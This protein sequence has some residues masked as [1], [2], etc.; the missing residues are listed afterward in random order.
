MRRV[1]KVFFISLASLILLMLAAVSIM[2]WLV[3]T[4]ER[5]T[6]IIRNQSAKHIPYQTEV[7]EVELTFFSTFPQFGIKIKNFAVISPATGATSDT[8]LRADELVG[9]IDTR[10]Y[11]ENREIIIN[12]FILSNSYLNIFTD[13]L[14]KSN[15]GLFMTGTE[16]DPEG[17]PD[18]DFGFIELEK[19]EFRKL[20]LSYADLPAKLITAITG[21]NA[22]I[23]ATIRGDIM[24]GLMNISNAVISFEYDGDKY[25]EDARVQLNIPAE[26]I[27]SRQL[28]ELEEAYAKIN[29]VGIT[30]NGSVEYDTF[31]ESFITD[32]RY[33]SDPSKIE[34]VIALIPPA[35]FPNF[36]EY[37]ASGVITSEGIIKGVLN[38]SLMPLMDIGIALADGNL[39]HD[40]LPFLLSE[41]KGNVHFF[42]DLAGN[43][44]SYLYV[45]HFECR[46]PNS[47]I[48]TSGRVNNLF[49][50][51]HYNLLTD[52]SVLV[53]EFTS[54]IPGDM[55]LE[56]NG[57]IEGQV[58]TDFFMS[59]AMNLALDR[60]KMSGSAL[61]T[62]FRMVYDSLSMSSNRG[63]IDFSLP[64]PGSSDRNTKFAFARIAS[65]TLKAGII[66]DF[67]TS[68]TNSHFYL[69]MSDIRDTTVIPDVFCTFNVGSFWAGMDTISI[70]IDRPLGYFTLSPV[71]G[72]ADQPAIRLAYNSYDL[73][74]KMG[75]NSVAVEDL[76]VNTDIVNDKNQEDIFLQWLTSG[77]IDMNNGTIS[78][79]GLSHPLEIP[80]IKMDFDP[81]TFNIS[82]SRLRIDQSDF[83]LTG[84]FSNVLSWFRGD[85]ILRGD[86]NFISGH[87]D[88]SQLM[89]LTSGIGVEDVDV[90][91]NVVVDNNNSFRRPYMVPQGM[92]VILRADV[93]QATM[94]SDT[95]TNIVGDIRVNDGILLL[96]GLTFTT[97]AADMQLTAMYR[98]PRK[99][100]LYLGLDYH[101]VD[102]EISRLLEMI[103]DIDTLMPMLR[104]F[105]G[106][107]EFHIAVETYLDS[108]YNIKKSTL[109]GASSIRGSDLVLMD[110]ETFGEIARTLRF[111]RRA[112]NRVDS[113]S[114]EFTIFREEID[115]YPF[116]I[117]MDRYKAVVAG[118]H[119]LDM[120][121][122][123]H[124]SL[125]E[126]PLPI[127]LGI[128]IGGTMDQMRYRLASPRYAEFYRPASRR[129]VESRQLELRRIIR[130][131]LMKNIREQAD[132]SN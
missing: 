93:R 63:Q 13:S 25:L 115:I 8:L 69:E 108:L 132:Q 99:N 44:E 78:I 129:A 106:S 53:D 110:T 15:Y 127:R 84:I 75:Q 68:M 27:I 33:K 71:A 57:R 2:L 100:H 112:E 101:M 122:D 117:V 3:F 124:I 61:L 34:D 32:I 118:R 85:S 83:G 28:A 103:P 60:M 80:S 62:D 7:G 88:L 4:P 70:A 56:L 94:G 87:T 18:M 59:E 51:M 126:S 9:V 39:R 24:K 46:T 41:M 89:Y 55:N 10:A 95:I 96:D 109:R 19:I 43:P 6:P 79:S 29:D 125:V 54:F 116:L 82:D 64:N 40:E 30:V 38:D 48:R 67:S 66:E 81:E 47:S 113:L 92:D 65:D 73:T 77:F 45:S 52:A 76:T 130:E 21:L 72:A 17:P 74:A 37:D 23:S 128:D 20:D 35:Y 49:G 107:G 42:W 11:R 1:L 104:S 119:N 58:R 12:K 102:V 26:I 97:P 105:K 36:G 123:Y 91:N 22:E 50:D 114:A 111:S 16:T 121:F 90:S 120:S 5:L 98:T 86:F 131:A 31:R 14:G